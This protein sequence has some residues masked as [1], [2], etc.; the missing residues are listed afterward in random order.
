M[1]RAALALGFLVAL[2]AR[3]EL[4][5][6][7]P[8]RIPDGVADARGELGFFRAR[9]AGIV[10]VDLSTGDIRWSSSEGEWLLHDLATEAAAPIAELPAFGRHCRPPFA[11][12]GERMLCVREGEGVPIAG[13]TAFARELVALGSRTGE[14]S[15]S[16]AIAPRLLPAPVP[17]AR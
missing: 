15:W 9:D 11:I 16:V 3:A 17:G 5:P 14:I 7:T 6:P 13:G 10:A 12:L 2:A 4:A 8:P 1:R